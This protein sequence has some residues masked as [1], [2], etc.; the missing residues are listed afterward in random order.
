MSADRL[1]KPIIGVVPNVQASNPE[2]KVD[3]DS[4][5]NPQVTD[6]GSAEPRMEAGSPRGN[7]TVGGV[8]SPERPRS[9]DRWHSCR[10]GR[11]ATDPSGIGTS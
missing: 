1:R 5:A 7:R 2:P 8:W 6:L 11:K 9:A 4:G 3:R 10:S